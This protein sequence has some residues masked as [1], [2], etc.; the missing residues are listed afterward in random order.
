[1]KDFNGN[2]MMEQMNTV[3]MDIVFNYDITCF[4]TNAFIPQ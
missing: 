2:S 3:K 1:M 4:V